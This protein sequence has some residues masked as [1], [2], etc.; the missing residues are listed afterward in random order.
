MVTGL[1]CE[2]Q[3]NWDRNLTDRGQPRLP[4]RSEVVPL[5][6]FRTPEYTMSATTNHYFGIDLYKRQS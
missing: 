2:E 1:G 5:H 6:V 3:E 4:A